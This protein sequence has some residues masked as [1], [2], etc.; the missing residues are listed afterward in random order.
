V[1][2]VNVC[3]LLPFAWLA[4]AHSLRATWIAC[5]ALTPIFVLVIRVGAGKR[6]AAGR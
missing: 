4:V 5:G 6:E 2:C 1:I 3:W